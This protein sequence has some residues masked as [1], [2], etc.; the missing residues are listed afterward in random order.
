M[1]FPII[2]MGCKKNDPSSSESDS[3]DTT[4]SVNTNLILI[5]DGAE[6]YTIVRPDDSDTKEMDA[7]KLLRAH[8]QKSGVEAT[9]VTDWK[10]NPVADC[11]IVVGNT[12]R[13]ESDDGIDL[14]S[15]GLSDG[16]FLIKVSKKRIYI[17][18]GT[19]SDTYAAT[20]YFL[21]EF[22]GYAGDANNVS[23]VSSASVPCDYEYLYEK[24]ANHLDLLIGGKK[25]NEFVISYGEGT[26]AN[27]AESSAKALQDFLSEYTGFK[28]SIQASVNSA[29]PSIIL[30]INSAGNGNLFSVKVQNGNLIITSDMSSGLSIGV[31][32]FIHEKL[33]VNDS[34][35]LDNG[36]IYEVDLMSTAVSYLDFGAKGDGKTDDLAAIIATHEYANKYGLP[37]KAGEGKTFYI[38]MCNKGAV[39][40]TST[41]FTGAKIIIDDRDVPW[42]ELRRVAIFN[43]VPSSA[44]YELN[45]L[46]SLKVGDTNIGT[47]LNEDSVV[48]ITE[49]GTKRYIRKG[50][51]ADNDGVDQNEILVVDKNGNISADSPV[52]WDYSN[53]TSAVVTPID[54]ETLTI[55]GGTFTTICNNDIEKTGYYWRGF[56]ITRSNVVVDGIEHYIE[57]EGE[58]GAPY[59]SFMRADDCTNITIKNSVFTPHKTYFWMNNGVRTSVGTYDISPFRVVNFTMKNCT[60]TIDILNQS[61]WGIFTSNFCKNIVFDGCKL[62]RIDA[63]QGVHN[64]KVLNSELGWLGCA[65][66]GS[67]LL[68]LEGSKIHGTDFINLRDDYG[69]SWH[70]DV[71]VKNCTWAPNRGKWLSD[72]YYS[73]I[74]GT[75]LQQH[76]F[77]YECYMPTNITIENLYIDDSKAT[78]AYKGIMLFKD[79]NPSRTSESAENSLPQTYYVTETVNISGITLASGKTWGVSTN[80]Y[81]FKDVQI[82]K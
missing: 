6:A 22:F 57:N 53:I 31:N 55:K 7:V 73:I 32:K 64:A 19:P 50:Y 24:E 61:Y 3:N 54:K 33:S 35:S 43:V 74:G 37:V 14:S 42:S 66:T 4:G 34:V 52:I 80:Q 25:I 21:S 30:N 11:E 41:D 16:E 5:G 60:Q 8:F 62:S 51:N 18:G 45:S 38:G 1:C 47:T 10:G 39:I 49:A 46:K 40:K 82:N 27:D 26:S 2:L 15:Y 28:P 63:H 69:S 71:V 12:T 75:N 20:E 9:V 77:G 67:G 36:F 70:G 81:M 23:G 59:Q 76:Y 13:P 17:I 72:S 29:V 58:N 48:I 56:L 79:I 65:M 78:T 44:S 68:Y